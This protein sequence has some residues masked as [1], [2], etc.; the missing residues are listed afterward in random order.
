MEVVMKI[1]IKAE[2]LISNDEGTPVLEYNI[3]ATLHSFSE[4]MDLITQN[5]AKLI[6]TIVNLTDM[7]KK[8]EVDLSKYMKDVSKPAA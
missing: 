7:D 3:D 6:E 2:A 8:P 1:Q 4:M 5:A